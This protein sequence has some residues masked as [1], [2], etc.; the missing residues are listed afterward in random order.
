MSEPRLLWVTRPSPF[1]ARTRQAVVAAG[2]GA[3]T[4]PALHVRRLG[5]PQLSEPTAV[6]FT[7]P[8]AVL[9]HPARTSWLA[10]PAF[11]V[12]DDAAA[13][14]RRR[15]YRDVRPVGTAPGELRDLVLGSVSRFGHVVHFAEREESGSPVEALRSSGLSAER[16]VVCES[17]KATPEQ[18]RSVSAALP[19]VDGI[20]IDSAAAGQVV[21]E[22]IAAAGWHGIV[23]C[24][25]PDCAAAFAT[26]PGLLVELPPSPTEDSL[27]ASLARFRGWPP[28][29]DLRAGVAAA[30]PRLRLVVS[31]EPGPSAR[32]DRGGDGPD[33]PPPAA[34]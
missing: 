22:C 20:L 4:V 3:L 21:A 29:A 30:A 5:S 14:A 17:I 23:F 10:L 13:L 25:C 32:L 15:G 6:V 1:N 28:G 34:A 18:L 12:G 2:H 31:N 27:L 16:A 8:H 9:H 19:F 24:R 11:V 33:D 7:S 26:L